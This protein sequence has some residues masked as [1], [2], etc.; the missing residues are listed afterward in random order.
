VKRLWD[1]FEPSLAWLSRRVYHVPGV[2]R[3]VERLRRTASERWR[4]SD[5]RWTV[6]GDYDRDLRMRVDRT[7]FIGSAL[8]W[9]GYHSRETRLLRRL[10]GPESVFVD[11]GANQGE[12]TVAAAKRVPRGRV[13]AVE[14]AP[15]L[16]EDLAGNVERNGFR[17]VTIVPSALA[18]RSGT[19]PLY[20]QE[21]VVDGFRNEGT[22]SLW[23][24]RERGRLVAEVPVE[25]LDGLVARLALPRVD[26]VKIDVEGAERAVI[27]GAHETLRRFAPLM[28]VELSDENFLT[29]GYRTQDLLADLHGLGYDA[30]LV[31]ADGRE[32]R[33]GPTTG[34][35]RVC[36]A[37]CRRTSIRV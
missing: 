21:A 8:Y 4:G 7:S 35:P 3:V 5:R 27:A 22:A 19:L 23:A 14:P 31:E 26:L 24:G 12:F 10:L 32:R 13:V 15:E 6:I 2:W 37:L 17:N 36:N 30:F 11:V 33:I 1:A 28:L 20:A 34:L 16:R 18:D 25:T 9:R 29:C